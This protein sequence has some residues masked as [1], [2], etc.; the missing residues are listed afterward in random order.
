[1]REIE[2]AQ[3]VPLI[4]DACGHMAVYY[5]PDVYQSLKDARSQETGISAQVMDILLENADVAVREHLPICQDTGLVTAYVTLGQD[6]HIDG[7]LVENIQKGVSQGYTKNH[8]RASAVDDPLFARRNTGDNTPA[9]IYTNVVEGDTFQI[10]LMAKGFGSENMSALKMLKPA[11][12]LDGVKQFV[13]DTIKA[14]GPNACPPMVVG[15]GIGG[16]FDYSA[17]LAKKALLRPLSQSNPDPHYADLEQQLLREANKLNIGPMGLHGHT[18]VLK[19]QTEYYPTH[20]AGLPCAV[21]ICCHACRHER[22]V[23]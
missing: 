17:Y 19:V 4:S 18:T 20:I 3:L 2:A 9:I 16:T 11:E 13:L 10:D 23:L 7:S 8:L 22:I 15:V 1:M 21:N 12:G 5:Q 6:I 14:A